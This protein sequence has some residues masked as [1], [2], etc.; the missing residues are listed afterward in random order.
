MGIPA[1]KV[2]EEEL[3]KACLHT[4]QE[5]VPMLS[6][7]QDTRIGRSMAMK[8]SGPAKGLLYCCCHSQ[9]SFLE[10]NGPRPYLDT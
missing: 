3:L 7:W 5:G 10:T 8:H 2:D 9:V 6:F 4:I 1:W